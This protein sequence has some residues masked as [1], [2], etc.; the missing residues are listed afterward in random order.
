MNRESKYNDTLSEASRVYREVTV[1]AFAI[2]VRD[3]ELAG[4]KYKSSTGDVLAAQD[5]CREEVEEAGAAY[6][7][8]VLVELEQYVA[9]RDYA[10][11]VYELSL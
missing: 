5:V 7:A 10:V 4:Q 9:M 3:C 1:D 2:Y 11:S 6:D 8:A